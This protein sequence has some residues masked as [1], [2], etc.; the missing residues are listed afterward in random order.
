MPHTCLVVYFTES[1]KEAYRHTQNVPSLKQ[2]GHGGEIEYYFSLP[3]CEMWGNMTTAANEAN[4]ISPS[5]VGFYPLLSHRSQKMWLG[6][7]GPPNF[8]PSDCIFVNYPKQIVAG[9]GK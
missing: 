4:D 9:E 6:W 2:R 8:T 3:L 5:C 1:V 7:Q